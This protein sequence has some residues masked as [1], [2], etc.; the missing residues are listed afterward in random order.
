MRGMV[1]GSYSLSLRKTF[2]PEFVSMN[3]L[4]AGMVALGGPW[5][6]GAGTLATP[7]H[8]AFVDSTGQ[9]S[10]NLYRSAYPIVMV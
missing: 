5:R 6:Q 4:M 8:P 3:G 2:L 7:T 10:A 1:S 9:A